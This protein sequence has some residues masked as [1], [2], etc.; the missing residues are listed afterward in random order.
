MFVERLEPI[1]DVTLEI[2]LL[3][4]N[5]CKYYVLFN[6]YNIEYIMQYMKK[7]DVIISLQGSLYVFDGLVS[8]KLVLQFVQFSLVIIQERF[9]IWLSFF[10]M[11]QE[12][13]WF[14]FYLLDYF[15]RDIF[16]LFQYFDAL[17]SRSFLK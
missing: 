4:I 8:V 6:L 3:F 15:N 11:F 1:Y 12:I 10:Q 16:E 13:L 9:D 14:S 5:L 7:R 2:P 17:A